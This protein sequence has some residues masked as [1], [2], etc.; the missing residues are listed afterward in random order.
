MRTQSYI[1]Q[2]TGLERAMKHE[3]AKRAEEETRLLKRYDLEN[4]DLEAEYAKIQ[5]KESYLS[6]KRRAVVCEIVE[7][8]RFNAE[9]NNIIDFDLEMRE[10]EKGAGK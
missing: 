5:R 4:I 1:E 3:L 2:I 6:S 9:V 7:A 10:A 8:R